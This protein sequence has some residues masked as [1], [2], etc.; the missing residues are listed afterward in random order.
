[1]GFMGKLFARI[2]NQ[3]P[4]ARLIACCDLTEAPLKEFL[5]A[6]KIAAGIFP[7]GDIPGMLNAHPEIEAVFVCTPED[8]HAEAACVAAQAGK[9]LFVEKPL[10]TTVA[11]GQ[12]IAMAVRDAGVTCMTGFC[13]R[14][15]PRYAGARD[16]VAKGEIG[17]VVH[18]YARRN[19]PLFLLRRLGGRV[20][21]TLWVGSHDLDMMLW[22][23]GGEVRSVFSRQAGAGVAGFQVDQAISSS[24]KFADGSIAVL[25]NIWGTV[26]TQG[27]H[28]RIEFQINGTL[29]TIEIH[30]AETGLGVF[31]EGSAVYPDTVYSPVI[32]GKITGVYREEIEY[33]VESVRNGKQPFATVEDGLNAVRVADAIE[34]SRS[35]GREI[36]L[37]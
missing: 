14:S 6:A 11:D 12:K 36:V 23:K 26:S 16:S 3:M 19:S 9:H 15:D 37:D 21:H 27:R 10:A 8:R 20:S 35:D 34:R 13:L 5:T 2:L 7:N 18:M 33:F 28:D 32:Q 25:E 31:R 4:N 30:P 22:I 17:E 24:L 1:M 29:G